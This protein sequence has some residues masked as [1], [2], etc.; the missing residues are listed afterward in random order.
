MRRTSGIDSQG[1]NVDR[2][3]GKSGLL[4]FL[5]YYRLIEC[6]ACVQDKSDDM[7]IRRSPPLAVA[8]NRGTVL[9]GRYQSVYSLSGHQHF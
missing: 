1:L 3:G 2:N 4:A 5:L 8:D 6:A 9:E 7:R